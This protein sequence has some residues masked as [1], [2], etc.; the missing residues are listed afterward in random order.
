MGFHIHRG[1]LGVNQHRTL[2]SLKV[3]FK[4]DLAFGFMQYLYY[5]N[6]ATFFAMHPPLLLMMALSL[7]K[8][9]AT[10]LL[11]NQPNSL[12]R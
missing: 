2:L 12:L 1:I 7:R 4:T 9:Y 6:I 11:K 3:F 8:P 10:C 5:D